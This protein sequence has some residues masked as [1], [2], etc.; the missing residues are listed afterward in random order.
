MRHF[1]Y[2]ALLICCVGATAPLDFAFRTAVFR[3]LR[4]V[5]L[6]VLPAFAVFMTWDVYAIAHQHWSYD[7]RWMTG[8]SLPGRVPLEE[9]LFF[10]VVPLAAIL[11]YEGVRSV[12]RPS[13]EVAPAPEAAPALEVAPTTESAL[14]RLRQEVE[15]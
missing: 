4:L 7:R 1:T 9:A 10:V 2:L 12:L 5:L 13:P 15:R 14:D 11:T 6:A 8:V 3:R